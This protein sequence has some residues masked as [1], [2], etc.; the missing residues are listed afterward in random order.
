[1]THTSTVVAG[2]DHEFMTVRHLVAEGDQVS[3]GHAIGQEA[4]ARA[5]W[6]PAAIDPR[7]GKARRLWFE[8][9]WRA[10]YARLSGIAAAYGIDPERDDLSFDSITGLPSGSGCSAVAV[11]A[12]STVDGHGL[13]G[14][15]YDF[16]TSGFDDL[17][18]EF[19]GAEPAANP[20]APMASRPYVLTTR[21]QHGLASTAVTMG[22]L[23]GATEGINEA[24]LAVALLLADVTSVEPPS[25]HTSLAGL[26]VMQVPR[27]LLDTCEDTEQAEIALRTAKLYD[28]GVGIHY[29]VADASGRSFVWERGAHDAEHV[30]TG[31]GPQCVTNHPLHRYPD[32]ANLPADTD[33]SMRTY[34]RART[35]AKNTGDGTVSGA[36]LRAA[37]DSV[38]M[39]A[40]PGAPWRT[41]WRSVFDHDARTMSTRFYLGD[42]TG[43]TA[44]YSDE[45]TFRP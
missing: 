14:R 8:R 33:E 21:P 23:D 41:L 3:I 12:S 29:L 13:T 24:G 30:L 5:N 10:H 31:D 34:E 39:P 25:E 35:L 18:A 22:D 17:I 2:G 43:E 20:G 27:Y 1:M 4:R 45:L 9:N 15:N 19:T 26:S 42:S 37:M 44:R 16:F 32:T 36:S 28:H 11:P 6:A 38:A 7:V 40:T